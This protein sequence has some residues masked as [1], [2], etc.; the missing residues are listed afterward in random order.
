[1]DV[2]INKKSETKREL[3]VVI[4]VAEMEDYLNKAA[5][6]L[7]DQMDIKGFR[8]GNA[9][10]EIVENSV[11]KEKLWEEAA[12]GA[13]QETY[14][15]I[16][17]EKDLFTISQPKVELMKCVPGNDV[18]YKAEVYIMP[19]IKLPDYKKIAKDVTEKESKDIEVTEKELEDTLGRIRESRAKIRRV[20]REAQEGDTVTINFVGSF[21][22]DSDKKIEE[23]DFKLNLGKGELGALKGFEEEIY[24][25]KE[26]EKKNFSLEMP[27]MQEEKDA[28]GKKVNIEVEMLSVMERE[29][30]EIN[31]EFASSLPNI[32]NVKELKE[33]VKEGIKAEKKNKEKERKKMMIMENI[34]KET[35][36][37]VPEVLI[38]KELDNII[39][40]LKH[41]VANS[42]ASFEDYLKQIGKTEE[43][44]R[45]ES[46]RKAEENVSYALILHAISN[47]ENIEVSNEEIEKEIEKHFQATG[48]KKEEEKEENMEKMRAYVYDVIKNQKVFQILSV[49]S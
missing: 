26:G 5:K 41:Q 45:K 30:P 12:K 40:N 37:E 1:M 38:E 24:G 3:E 15:K 49:E 4:S 35:D 19:E 2:K 20:E 42:G 10:R 11:G 14:P 36:F 22:D 43:D 25:M 44:L 39:N 6:E 32:E 9:P 27:P 17:E 31:D 46:R 48:R 28:A 29:L 13:I 21:E 47:E 33:K 23:K 18:V 7:S 8:P 16:V 34:K